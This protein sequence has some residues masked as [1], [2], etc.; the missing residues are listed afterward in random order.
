MLEINA[1]GDIVVDGEIVAFVI[2]AVLVAVCCR[3]NGKKPSCHW[4][5]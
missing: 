3:F 5:L 2:G 4:P 1:A